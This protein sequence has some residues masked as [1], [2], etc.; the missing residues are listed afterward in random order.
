VGKSK[1]GI[2]R[3]KI[4]SDITH[5]SAHV[6][7]GVLHFGDHNLCGGV[8]P[9]Q[10]EEAYGAMAWYVT[11]AF[12][13]TDFPETIRRIDQHFGAS[14]YSLRS[15]FRDEQRTVLEQIM[16]LTLTEVWSAYGR[17]YSHH[18][19]LMRFHLELGVPLPRPFQVTA[20]VILNYHLRQAFQAP[21]LDLQAIRSFIEEAQL[22]Q[23][24]L[25]ATGL[26]FAFRKAVERL[27]LEFQ[28]DPADLDCLGKL[29]AAVRLGSELPFDVNLWKLQN[30]YYE[31][32]NS[33]YPRWR[34]QSKKGDAKPSAWREHFE[35]LGQDLS[36]RVE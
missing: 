3:I 34:R 5:D 26:E 7:F 2:G 33:V 6:S 10:G 16:D 25:D 14:T 22:L 36:V 30:I 18:V 9:F 17:I 23:V 1:L 8:R 13:W 21:E 11:E 15:L 4:T 12:S 29:T 20:E 32:L 31:M 19:P 27:A 35:A 28:Q 24:A